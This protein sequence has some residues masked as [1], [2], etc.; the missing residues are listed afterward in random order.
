MSG[1]VLSLFPGI[2]MLD[3]AFE[4]HGFCVV[5]GPDVL[6][7]GDIRRFHPPS[8]RFDGVIGGPPCQCFS[9]LRHLNPLAGKKKPNLI[10]E[11]VRCV[12]SAMPAWFLMENVRQAIA[13]EIPGYAVEFHDV[14]DSEVGGFTRRRRRFWFGSRRGVKLYPAGFPEILTPARAVTSNVRIPGHRHWERAK[15]RGGGVLPGDGRYATID[16]ICKL[17]GLPGGFSKDGPFKRQAVRI[18]LGNG[19]PMAM[20]RAIAKAVREAIQ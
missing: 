15:K 8:D 13:P 20:G 12:Q 17:Q 10:P 11:F 18:M 7:G 9:E 2:G 4:E 3:A 19:V 6:W 5:R 1:L 14:C 16:E